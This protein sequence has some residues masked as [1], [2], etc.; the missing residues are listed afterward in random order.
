MK[1]ALGA[2]L[3]FF[4]VGA[5]AQ[6]MSVSA[7]LTIGS[8]KRGSPVFEAQRRTENFEPVLVHSKQ[9]QIAET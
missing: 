8:M 1:Y 6:Q 5:S 4:A 7:G 2:A 3:A 9:A